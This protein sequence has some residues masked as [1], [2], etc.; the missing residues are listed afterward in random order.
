MKNNK[1]IFYSTAFLAILV[2]VLFLSRAAYA[3]PVG[4][5]LYRTSKDG[6]IYGYSTDKLFQLVNFSQAGKLMY[7]VRINSGH[8]GVYVGD[9]DG[10]GDKVLEAIDGGVILTPANKF[11]NL[12]NKE[13]L[14]GAKIPRVISDA[15]DYLELQI[16]IKEIAK[17]FKDNKY[18][19]DF[20]LNDQKG[21]KSGQWTCVGLVEKIY[22]S[23]NLNRR[24]NFDKE[25]FLYKPGDKYFL[26]I[27]SD[28]YDADTIFNALNED[29]LAETSE[30]SKISRRD[31]E[32]DGY[33]VGKVYEGGRYFFLPYTQFIQPTLKNV[34]VDISLESSFN[35]EDVRGKKPWP[36][37]IIGIADNRVDGGITL[38]SIITGNIFEVTKTEVSVATKVVYKAV[39]SAIKSTISATAS[40]SKKIINFIPSLLK[41][42]GEA[43]L[44]SASVLV[45][46]NGATGIPPSVTSQNKSEIT[47][48][49]AATELADKFDNVAVPVVEVVGKVSK[50]KDLAIKKIEPEIKKV[51]PK[52]IQQIKS[53]P[54]PA[55]SMASEKIIQEVQPVVDVGAQKVVEKIK[56]AIPVSLPIIHYPPSNG[57]VAS[58]SEN[59]PPPNKTEEKD[60]PVPVIEY[61]TLVDKDSLSKTWTNETLITVFSNI[62]NLSVVENFALNESGLKPSSADWSS[63][64][65]VDY[66][67]SSA[68]GQKTVYSWISYKK[69]S[70]ATSA[71]ATIILDAT[72]P[73]SSLLVLAESYEKTGWP[74]AW[75]GDDFGGSGI[76]YFSIEYSTSSDWSTWLLETAS[77]SDFFD[78]P[79]AQNSNIS[80]RVKA[81]DKAGNFGSWSNLVTTTIVKPAHLL[82]SEFSTRG[83]AGAY[84]EFVELYNPSNQDISLMGW[85]L[86]SK[87]ATASS[88]WVSRSGAG[89]P[90]IIIPAH[91]FFLLTPAS[92]SDAISPDYLHS[93]NWG[94]ADTGGSLRLINQT[95]NE[96]DKIDYGLVAVSTSTLANFG[97]NN[98]YTA[99][100]K[101]SKDSTAQTLKEAEKYSGNSFDTDFGDDFVLK[102][103]SFPQNLSTPTEP[104]PNSSLLPTIVSDLSGSAIATSS[105]ILNWTT[106]DKANFHQSAKYDIRYAKK[107]SNCATDLIWDSA[108]IIS[109]L[110][111]PVNIPATPQSVAVMALK[112]GQEYCFGLKTFNGYNWSELSNL[113]MATTLSLPK[114]E[115]IDVDYSPIDNPPGLNVYRNSGAGFF[116]GQ[117]FIPHQNNITAISLFG[118]RNGAFILHLCEG[119]WDINQSTQA[120]FNCDLAGQK[121]LATAIF[122][123]NTFP[124]CYSTF[125]PEPCYSQQF[126]V[127]LS[128]ASPVAIEPNKKHFFILAGT[129]GAITLVGT[130]SR[131]WPTRDFPDGRSYFDNN[132]SAD[133]DFI[134]RTSY[135]P[136]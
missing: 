31:W 109:S 79:L 39:V 97:K 64:V 26:D 35:D 25:D 22:E 37:I 52:I 36:E 90:N 46:G 115:M 105:L 116:Y 9:I 11:I 103:D 66:S 19:Y 131:L 67:L 61:L 70:V 48:V 82:I 108:T 73:T 111:L 78:L 91:S 60:L 75:S 121:L 58:A 113:V 120:N 3:M 122:P 41:G 84:D 49:R 33:L 12:K 74:V 123:N 7:G 29:V 4:T 13:K 63:Q 132:P 86:Q 42:A 127:K 57:S 24:N 6:L 133:T 106:P 32:V 2:G 59:N 85:Q 44:N 81:I 43:S 88:T 30:Y 112:P 119:D 83:S 65:A 135:L 10:T 8:V 72:K 89:L 47:V 14:V 50:A 102:I 136:D 68:D 77:T 129:S 27:T 18:E 40:A 16:K 45:K 87:A 100:R 71:S 101:A 130:Q 38:S 118:K 69:G 21:P 34:E 54:L 1:I 51:S 128:F 15:S 117:S 98:N 76:K 55:V 104:N 28:G 56:E 110:P 124:G 23:L 95:V 107:V 80:F 94:L 53:V 92:Y 99:E 20:T 114:L 93:A 5:L 17:F 126:F 96:I 62:A 125:I 134:F